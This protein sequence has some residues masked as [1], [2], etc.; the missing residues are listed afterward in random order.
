MT[1]RRSLDS[2]GTFG[3]ALLQGNGAHLPSEVAT[4]ILA[5]L[6]ESE[7][8]Q[9]L[10]A[11]VRFSGARVAGVARS[12]KKKALL[13]IAGCE[14]E[15]V[16]KAHFDLY[17]ERRDILEA[18]L[19]DTGM[20]A[21][22]VLEAVHERLWSAEYLHQAGYEAHRQLAARTL[23]IAGAIRWIESTRSAQ[24][25]FDVLGEH[26]AEQ[27][28]TDES[29]PEVLGKLCAVL[30]E[31]RIADCIGAIC[32][33]F[34]RA[35]GERDGEQILAIL[36]QARGAV[37]ERW[38]DDMVAA[39]YGS[40][41]IITLPLLEMLLERLASP[42]HFHDYQLRR[43]AEGAEAAQYAPSELQNVR[44][45]YTRE[46]Y[47]RLAECFPGALHQVVSGRM[48]AP[49]DMEATEVV[50]VALASNLSIL[51]HGLL[52]NAG[53]GRFRVE[54]D[55]ERFLR[56]L[57]VYESGI[58]MAGRIFRRP[59]LEARG[60][61]Q[62]LPDGAT[63]EDVCRLARHV[64]SGEK[65]LMYLYGS[66]IGAT[67][68]YVP[69][70]AELAILISQYEPTV[71]VSVFMQLLR[72]WSDEGGVDTRDRGPM[73]N[74]HPN[75]PPVRRPVL[76]GAA[77]FA[78]IE[79]VIEQIPASEFAG[80]SELAREFMLRIFWREFGETPQAWMTAI[81]LVER[82]DVPLSKVIRAARLLC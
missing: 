70:P 10:P 77:L 56:A 5:G 78:Y 75:G 39:A 12:S 19:S 54:L 15:S 71:R 45:R 80:R 62:H 2:H 60:A 23:P 4:E 51:A 38:F 53:D 6:E 32:T 69:N 26:L 14:D 50:D 18:A 27:W 64:D 52:C 59:A 58:W 65:Y 29:G 24:Y 21:P 1:T 76:I 72:I 40:A 22:S 13:I 33:G 20:L 28:T 46:A 16:Q 11:G 3:L 43:I 67:P 35:L 79:A 17:F 48:A 74:R 81:A 41:R 55:R 37:G 57:D 31:A 82:A 73:P 8:P 49:E 47:L 36:C 68:R 9:R 25:M 34:G 63:I 66:D 61:V 7:V 42:E 30:R 44:G